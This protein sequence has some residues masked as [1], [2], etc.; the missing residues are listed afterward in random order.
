MRR[1]IAVILCVVLA[2]SITGCASDEFFPL[3]HEE[4]TRRVRDLQAEPSFRSVAALDSDAMVVFNAISAA[5]TE[6]DT[7]SEWIYLWNY[8]GSSFVLDEY[9][10]GDIVPHHISQLPPGE[11]T[12]WIDNRGAVLAVKIVHS[13]TDNPDWL[14]DTWR[15]SHSPERRGGNLF[16]VFPALNRGDDFFQPNVTNAVTMPP[17]LPPAECV[18]YLDVYSAWICGTFR[19]FSDEFDEAEWMDFSEQS[20]SFFTRETFTAVLDMGEETIEHDTADYGYILTVQTD[21]PDYYIYEFFPFINYI[22]VDDVYI[23][24]DSVNVGMGYDSMGLRVSITDFW[25]DTPVVSHF[26]EIGEFSRLE[27]EMVIFH[28]CQIIA[29]D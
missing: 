7:K 6:A 14:A 13:G 24:F 26:S 23:D 25:T 1:I 20:V 29:L 12:V 17:N 22:K 28:N 5:I 16:G 21:I 8:K 3:N 15:W 18:C 9:T 11:I 2:V 10:A 27:V 4:Q 19:I